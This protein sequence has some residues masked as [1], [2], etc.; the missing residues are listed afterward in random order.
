[1][2]KIYCGMHRTPNWLW[3]VEK[4]MH[5][6]FTLWGVWGGKGEMKIGKK[7]YSLSKGD[8]FLLDYNKSIYATQTDD[9]LDVKYID[10]SKSPDFA[11]KE[12]KV[13]R[14][15]NFMNELF[16]R[17]KNAVD[18]GRGD[19]RLWLDALLTEYSLSYDDSHSESELSKAVR[20]FYNAAVEHP[21]SPISVREYA[22]SVFYSSDHFIREFKKVYGISPYKVR[23]KFKFEKACSLLLHSSLS[24]AEISKHCGFEDS[25]SFSK[26]FAAYSGK[27]PLAFKKEKGA[28]RS[29]LQSERS[30]ASVK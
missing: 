30:I 9:F 23:Q 13:M 26:F 28:Q 27:S 20:E 5:S 25:N 16:S 15:T 7:T 8:I 6:G 24:I 3:Q 11:Y 29:G 17:A 22:H 18:S 14:S 1:M 21:E 12:H 4:G 19:A 2:N 10:F